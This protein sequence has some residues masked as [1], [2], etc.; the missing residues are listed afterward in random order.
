MLFYFLIFFLTLKIFKIN[1]IFVKI[2]MSRKILYGKVVK[3]SSYT[4]N[5]DQQYSQ[6]YKLFKKAAKTY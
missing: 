4:Y 2:Q 5:I 1:Q 6:I 3:G